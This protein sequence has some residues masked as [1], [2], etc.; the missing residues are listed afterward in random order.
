MERI[1]VRKEF[2]LE[3]TNILTTLGYRGSYNT[4]QHHCHLINGRMELVVRIVKAFMVS[5]ERIVLVVIFKSVCIEVASKK[6]GFILL[7]FQS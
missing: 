5:K 4:G 2:N 1:I 7:L 6:A 3:H